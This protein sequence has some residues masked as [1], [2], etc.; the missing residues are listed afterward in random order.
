[1]NHQVRQGND[2]SARRLEQQRLDEKKKKELEK[3]RQAEID[4]LF[5]PVQK[6][7]KGK[8]LQSALISK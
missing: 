4:K 7:E 1:M 2:A 6:L 8:N 3:K 5:K